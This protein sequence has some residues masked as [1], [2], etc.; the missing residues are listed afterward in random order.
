MARS[1]RT[2]TLK[3]TAAVPIEVEPTSSGR[4]R[5]LSAKQQQIG[6][7]K[8]LADNQK[9]SQVLQVSHRCLTALRQFKSKEMWF[10]N[11]YFVYR[12]C[13]ADAS[14]VYRKLNASVSQEERRH[15]IE[16]T[17]ICRMSKNPT[18]KMYSEA[19]ILHRAWDVW[20][21]RLVW[22]QI[23]MG[24]RER[25]MPADAQL[26]NFDLRATGLFCTQVTADFFFVTE[27]VQ[28]QVVAQDKAYTQA[29]RAHQAQEEI[30]GFQKLPVHARDSL[31][32]DVDEEMGPESEDEDHPASAG[33]GLQV[34]SNEANKQ[35]PKL[36]RRVTGQARPPVMIGPNGSA[37]PPLTPQHKWLPPLS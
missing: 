12:K 25:G 20:I 6:D 33:N 29:L 5:T 4:Q 14:Q 26:N 2:S 24:R 23:G 35:P 16:S 1:T 37:P 32:G 27:K 30:M 3:A 19:E 11:I 21:P 13:V 15:A 18:F 31:S 10:A 28:K 9:G 17:H 36:I 7:R 34:H 8:R 22:N